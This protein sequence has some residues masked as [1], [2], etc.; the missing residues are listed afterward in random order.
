MATVTIKNMPD[1]LYAQ[2]K[3][4]AKANRRSINSEILISLDQTL[5]SHQDDVEE[6]IAQARV[7]REHTAHYLLTDE[8]LEQAINEGRP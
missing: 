1:E 5:R 2:I 4:R 6:I 3:R 7:V 8:V